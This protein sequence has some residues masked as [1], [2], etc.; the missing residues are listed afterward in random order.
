MKIIIETLLLGELKQMAEATFGNLVKAVVDVERELI[1]V[2]AE[3]HSDLEALLLDDGS[4]QKSLWGI[5]IYPE[6]QGNDFVEFDSMINMRPSQ[7]NRS[8]GIENEEMRKKIIAIVAKRI[9]R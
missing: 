2:D 6:I 8:R 9:K 4:R 5:N 1:A 3:L 7:G